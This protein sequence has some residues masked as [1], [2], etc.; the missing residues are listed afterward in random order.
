MIGRV[1]PL[2]IF[3]MRPPSFDQAA[4]ASSGQES[5]ALW[6]PHIDQRIEFRLGWCRCKRACSVRVQALF[7][8]S[9][10]KA[11][12]LPLLLQCLFTLADKTIE[13]TSLA[14]VQRQCHCTSSQ[15]LNLLHHRLCLIGMAAVSQDNVCPLAASFNAPLRPKP[16]F[17]PVINATF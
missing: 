3:R 14:D 15:R 5:K 2:E 1:R 11:L 16:R 7:A 17:A 12:T 6:N 8:G 10:R 9:V 4:A 13:L